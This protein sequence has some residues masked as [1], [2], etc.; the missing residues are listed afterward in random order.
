MGV[1]RPFWFIMGTSNNHAFPI[2]SL[3][4]SL[5]YNSTLSKNGIDRG[6]VMFDFWA[7][8]GVGNSWPGNS[9]ASRKGARGMQ[10]AT[11]PR[12]WVSGRVARVVE[13]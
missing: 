9:I 3:R 7:P 8:R 4:N 13:D 5:I 2:S 10:G 6:P 11:L 1:L 12:D